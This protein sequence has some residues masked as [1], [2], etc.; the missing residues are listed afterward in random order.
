MDDK[1]GESLR[2]V[3]AC[4]NFRIGGWSTHTLTLAVELKR[5]GYYVIALV[6]DPFGEL[7]ERFPSR[8]RRGRS[9]ATRSGT[10]GHISA[11]DS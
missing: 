8:I 1:R 10:A 5:V 2:I 6:L 7:Y 9:G 3:I 11:Q 4:P